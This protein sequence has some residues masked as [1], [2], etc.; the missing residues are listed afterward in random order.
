M[1]KK[2]IAPFQHLFHRPAELPTTEECALVKRLRELMDLTD[3]NTAEEPSR[4]GRET[5]IVTRRGR[6]IVTTSLN[7]RMSEEELKTCRGLSTHS[8]VIAVTSRT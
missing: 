4:S 1:I 6:L 3:P 5:E 2:F 7:S 8:H